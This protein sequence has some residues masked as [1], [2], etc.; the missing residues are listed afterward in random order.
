MYVQ[1]CTYVY[2][3]QVPVPSKVQN[4]NLITCVLPCTIP[5]VRKCTENTH[6]N[7][8]SYFPNQ[9]LP[10]LIPTIP[11][12]YKHNG[13]YQ[14]FVRQLFP[15]AV[16]TKESL[17]IQYT[18]VFSHFCYFTHQRHFKILPVMG[19]GDPF[20]QDVRDNLLRSFGHVCDPCQ[21]SFQ[22]IQAHLTYASC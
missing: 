5:I 14:L 6:T 8:F 20:M 16:P 4:E 21:F 12:L 10:R 19:L 13:P 15:R 9:L 7:L 22:L 17:H 3:L 2:S 1:K 11:T 18:F